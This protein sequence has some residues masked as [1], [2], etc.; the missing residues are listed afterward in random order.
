MVSK[1]CETNSSCKQTMSYDAVASKLAMALILI[2]L[3]FE[4]YFKPLST[5]E[6]SHMCISLQTHQQLRLRIRRWPESD[7]E[8]DITR[9]EDLSRALEGIYEQKRP[10]GPQIPDLGI[11]LYWA[12]RQQR[13]SRIPT[14]CKIGS[15]SCNGE[16]VLLKSTDSFPYISQEPKSLRIFE[17]LR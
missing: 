15:K 8:L 13:G 3:S 10:V 4:T 12:T 14:G 17:L 2:T 11:F 9:P 6:V 16:N 1:S 7:S 5:V